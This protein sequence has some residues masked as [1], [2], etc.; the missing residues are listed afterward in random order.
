MFGREVDDRIAPLRYQLLYSLAAPVIEAS[1]VG[2]TIGVLIVHEFDSNHLN[3]RKIAAN[4]AA[5]QAFVAAIPGWEGEIIEPG[6]LLPPI[7]LPGAGRVPGTIPVTIGKV[8]T[9]LS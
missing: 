7:L 4:A 1:L 5:L 9:V 6:T 2:A 3:R 8:R